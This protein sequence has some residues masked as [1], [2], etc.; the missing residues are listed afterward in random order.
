MINQKHLKTCNIIT[1]PYGEDYECALTLPCVRTTL[2]CRKCGSGKWLREID[3]DIETC[4][5]CISEHH[6]EV[7]TSCYC[8]MCM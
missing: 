5:N 6:N 8:E 2:V 4:F 1:V 7:G 3:Q